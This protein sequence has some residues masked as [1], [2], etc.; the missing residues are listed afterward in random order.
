MNRRAKTKEITL[1][2]SHLQAIGKVASEWAALEFS[3]QWAMV[4]MSQ[5][6]YDKVVA[7]TSPSPMNVWLDILTN[8]MRLQAP[9]ADLP[10]PMS[11]LFEKIREAQKN[12]NDI[13][14]AVWMIQ[15][16]KD[17]G[18]DRLYAT[19]KAYG[20]IFPKKMKKLMD[21][22]AFTAAEM[23]AIARDIHQL[24]DEFRDRFL[25]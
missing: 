17:R 25:K 9:D 19:D 13:V 6:P 18:K 21:K 12:R 20:I 23:R 5:V 10:K 16:P 22:R 7:F 3:F 15:F 14:H 8:L 4:K 24:A 2:P 11:I 1:S